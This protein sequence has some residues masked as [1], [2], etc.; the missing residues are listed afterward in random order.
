MRTTAVTQEPT[1]TWDQ[2][3]VI[4]K[5]ADK[6]ARKRGNG[7]KECGSCADEAERSGEK[8]PLFPSNYQ[9]NCPRCGGTFRHTVPG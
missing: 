4:A 9:G 6:A 7:R 2:Y 5:T 3:W 8:C 1:M